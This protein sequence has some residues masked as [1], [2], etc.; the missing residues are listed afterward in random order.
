M[1]QPQI[2]YVIERINNI[3]EQKVR[4]ARAKF[5]TPEVRLNE[6]QKYELVVKGKVKLFPLHKITR[7]GNADWDDAFDFSAFE[8]MEVFDQKKYVPLAQLIDKKAQ[9]ARDSVVLGDSSEAMK[10]LKELEAM[11]I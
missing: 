2:K 10:I 9:E 4:E 5:T 3:Q 1:R 7:H 8:S 6:A 11:S